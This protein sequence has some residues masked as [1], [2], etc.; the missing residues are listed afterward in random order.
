[1]YAYGYGNAVGGGEQCIIPGKYS[2]QKSRMHSSC[3]ILVAVGSFCSGDEGEV[4]CIQ[5]SP[6]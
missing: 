5:T 2:D 4:Q 3:R 6:V 1:M